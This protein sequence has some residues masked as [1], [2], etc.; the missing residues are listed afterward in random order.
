[1]SSYVIRRLL[2]LIPTVFGI[3]LLVFS[4]MRFLPGDVVDGMIGAEDSFTPG[5]RETMQ[6]LLGLDRPVHEQYLSW[7]GAVLR[8]DFGS[9][10][11]SAK[12]IGPLMW[13][14]LQVTAELALL[15]ILFSTLIAVPLG[16]I[17]AVR[18]NGIV[19]WLAQVIGLLGL[20]V[21]S[22]WLALLLLLLA[23]RQFQ[24]YPAIIWVSPFDDLRANLEQMLLPV[25]AMSGSLIAIIM[26]MTRSAMLEVMNQ[27]YIRTARAKGLKERIVIARHAFRNAL[28]P[29]VTI[30]G[31]Q[32][33]HLLGGSVVVEQIFG[34][35]GL[36]SMILTAINQ[37]DY[38][39]VQGGVLLIAVMF[40]LINIVVDLLY[41]VSDP[42]IRYS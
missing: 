33:G 31:L 40:V 29:V 6:R 39:V 14:R 10:L 9:S 2:L 22:F 13:D 37:R 36:G 26:R 23:S 8:F 42:R 21:P 11:R 12:P 3:S 28:I 30:V 20:S 7:M 38:P 15:A 16:I 4:L 25:L 1:M 24:W 5:Q 34:L 41:A 17:A 35:P 27:D 18:R 32:L 19:A